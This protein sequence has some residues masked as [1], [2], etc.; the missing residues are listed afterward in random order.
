MGHAESVGLAGR[1][2]PA[3]SPAGRLSAWALG[4]GL[5]AGVVAWLVGETTVNTFRPK[6]VT[7][8]TPVGRMTAAPADEVVRTDVKNAAL[9]FAVQGACLGLVLGLAG[10]LARG[11]ARTGAAAG[12][13]GAVLGAALA[14]GA[15]A[16]LQQV[17]YRNLQLDQVDQDLVVPM[18]VHGGIWGAAGLAGGWAFGMGLWGGW[19]STIRAAIGGLAG[20]RARRVPVRGDGSDGVSQGRDDPPSLADPRVAADGQADGVD[21]LGGRHRRPARRPAGVA[22]IGTGTHTSGPR[23]RPALGV[24]ARAGDRRAVVEATRRKERSRAPTSG[25]RPRSTLTPRDRSAAA[26]FDESILVGADDL[27]AVAGAEAPPNVPGDR[28]LDETDAAVGHRGVHPTRVGTGGAHAV[29]A[30]GPVG[31]VSTTT[32]AVEHA[33]AERVVGRLDGVEQRHADH[34]GRPPPA[35]V[36]LDR[37]GRRGCAEPGTAGRRSGGR[38]SRRRGW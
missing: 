9:A 17:Y 13:A 26:L 11:S 1:S 34:A 5:L 28:A 38:R 2:G 27:A 20:A 19:S 14:L 33:A 32:I 8:D 31:R 22:T 7:T 16:A 15:S 18:L 6:M 36:V 23:G 35:G 30:V 10:G 24:T 3:P 37:D 21:T 12:L 29:A 4:A 25:V